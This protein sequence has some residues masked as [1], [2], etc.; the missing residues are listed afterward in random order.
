MHGSCDS[1][2]VMEKDGGVSVSHVSSDV[3]DGGDHV[4]SGAE[5]LVTCLQYLN[6]PILM[7]WFMISTHLILK[8]P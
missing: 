5:K 3:T 4:S 6:Q 2:D 7:L 1:N 8:I